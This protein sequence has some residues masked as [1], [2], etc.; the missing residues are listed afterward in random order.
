MARRHRI[1]LVIA[2]LTAGGAERQLALLTQHVDHCEFDI[3]LLLFNSRD[4][5]HYRGVIDERIWLRTLELSPTEDGV[6]LI[7][8]LI[9]GIRNA[10][11]EWSPDL[12]HTSLN[13]ANHATRF[14]ALISRWK[15]PIVTSIRA[16]FRE[17]YSARDRFL[18]RMLW[19]RTNYFICNSGVSKQQLIADL[20]VNESNIKTIPNGVE[21]KFFQTNIV[22]KP[23]WWPRGRS[24]LTVARLKDGKNY[25]ELVFAIKYLADNDKLGDWNF[26]FVGEGPQKKELLEA[27]KKAKIENR[28]VLVEPVEDLLPIY[29]SADVFL[30][31][32]LH[33]GLSNVLLEAQAMQL[34]IIVTKE[35][36]RAAA[37]DAEHAFLIDATNFGPQLESALSSNKHELVERGI[38]M[39][40]SIRQRYSVERMVSETCEI[41]RSLLANHV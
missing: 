24:C 12:I 15:T 25:L 19:R 28:V 38:L 37:V 36:N 41:W 26:V 33:E 13:I 7:P 10:I 5:I 8:R 18:E 35:A 2:G 21:D 34:P 39:S 14:S 30:L 29:H 31:P 6:K 9:S 23:K 17:G 20:G 1:L 32:S 27:I 40:Q 11:A 4:R 22:E 16:D 3:G